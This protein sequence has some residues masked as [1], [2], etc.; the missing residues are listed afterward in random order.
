MSSLRRA[1]CGVA[2]GGGV[3]SWRGRDQARVQSQPPAVPVHSTAVPADQTYTGAKHCSSCHFK[4]YMAWK[5]TKH[6]KEAWESVPAKY[7]SGSRVPEVPRHG[8]RGGDG[9]QGCSARLPTWPG[10]TCEACHGPG[11][12]HEEIA[13]KFANKRS[14]IRTRRKRSAARS[15][16]SCRRTS[17]SAATSPRLTKSTRS[18][19]S[20]KLSLH[21][22]F[23]G[24]ARGDACATGRQSPQVRGSTRGWLHEAGCAESAG[25]TVGPAGCRK[26]AGRTN[27]RHRGR[28]RR[29]RLPTAP[30]EAARRPRPHGKPRKATPS[31]T[32][33]TTASSATRRSRR[34]TRSGSWSRPRTSP[35]TPIG[36]RGSAARTA[37]AAI[38]RCARSRPTRRTTIFAW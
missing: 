3:A 30:R 7:Q 18:T 35:G 26:A 2:V 25:R 4:Q 6:A 5:K 27:R 11:S 33:R 38:P 36:R 22:A 9:L 29:R 16:R 34:R 20:S 13:K 12:K 1:Y 14:W 28:P 19:T 37:T 8:L 15:T 23:A 10:T 21:E 24:F 31:R 32:T 17:A